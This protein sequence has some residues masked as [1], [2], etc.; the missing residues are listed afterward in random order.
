MTN[1]HDGGRSHGTTTSVFFSCY[2][3]FFILDGC[4]SAREFSVRVPI[5][6]PLLLLDDFRVRTL[7][8]PRDRAQH[9]RLYTIQ[10]ML[11]KYQVRLENR[12]VH[13]VCPH[14][15]QRTFNEQSCKLSNSS[16]QWVVESS[17]QHSSRL[18]QSTRMVRYQCYQPGA[19]RR[20]RCNF[21]RAGKI[22]RR[23]I[24]R[25][26]R[27]STLAH[28]AHSRN[29][30]HRVRRHPRATSVERPFFLRVFVFAGRRSD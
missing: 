11:S 25:S 17:L 12:F 19:C 1:T 28:S 23:V 6:P 27:G 30:R 26:T 5:P 22:G 4:V 9:T 2:P 21:P 29:D 18:M 20:L 3:F 16:L 7:T 14:A 15:P 8:R 10:K 13:A 24:D